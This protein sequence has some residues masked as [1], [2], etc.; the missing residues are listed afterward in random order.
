MVQRARDWL[1]QAERDLEQAEDSRQAG[2]HE[3]AC[4]AAQQAAEKAV[5]ALHLHYGQ[6]AWG[7]VVARLL[8]ELPPQV[9]V[10]ALLVEKARVLD[11]FY[12]PPRYPNSFAEGAPFEHYGPL[13]SEEAIQYAREIVDFVRAQ[14]A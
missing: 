9:A 7:H 14:M 12:I 13:Q 2:R 8:R 1:R 5:K 6:E 4:F 11:G 10:P 3:W